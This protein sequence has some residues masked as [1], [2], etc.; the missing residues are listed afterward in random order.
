VA[1]CQRTTSDAEQVKEQLDEISAT[2]T[3]AIEEVR[4]IAHNL[5]PYELDRLGLVA[6]VESMIGRVAGSTSINLSADLERIDGLLSLEAETSVYRILQEGLNNVVRHSHATAA[7][8]EIKRSGRQL[9]IAVHDNGS[10]MSPSAAAHMGDNDRGFGLTG[11]SERVRLLGGSH[12]ID[13][14]PANGTRLTVRLDLSHV[15]AE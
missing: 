5:R 4:E 12:T 1:I 10:G 7:Q 13:S 14:A 9:I 3:S 11:I 8:I 2:A 6:A 15:A